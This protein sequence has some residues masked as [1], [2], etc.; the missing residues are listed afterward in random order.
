MGKRKPFKFV[1]VLT[2][3]P[4]FEPVVSDYWEQTT[5][6]FVSTSALF[7]LTKKLKAIKPVL[8][9]LGRDKL[10]DLTKRAKE[11]HE[12]LCSMQAQTLLNPTQLNMELESRAYTKW[13]QLSSLEEGY[14][15]Q[16]AK[17]HWL[18]VGD[19]NNAI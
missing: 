9:A 4:Q 12:E 1:N 16:K 8:R 2:A 17:L 19:K 18:A 13:Q 6:L 3:L 10:G 7:R 5:P 14:L 15:K 11:A